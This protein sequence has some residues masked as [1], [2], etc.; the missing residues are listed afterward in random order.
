[1]PWWCK[2]KPRQEQIA[3]HLQNKQEHRQLNCE[4]VQWCRSF[5]QRPTIKH[6][7]LQYTCLGDADKPKTLRHI[8]V[9][10]FKARIVRY[11]GKTDADIVVESSD[12]QV[13]VISSV[14]W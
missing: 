2:N 14:W 12:K 1:M 4:M 10:V 11:R 6:F 9:P 3:V 5:R 13:Y 7:V 8:D